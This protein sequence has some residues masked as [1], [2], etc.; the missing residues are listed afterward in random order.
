M[1]PNLFRIALRTLWKNRLSTVV[2]LTGLSVAIGCS[3]ISFLIINRSFVLDNFHENRDRIYQVGNRI[4]IS[5]NLEIWADSP[6][7]LGPAMAEAFPQIEHAV[8]VH[9]VNYSTR[10]GE[11][12]LNESIFFVDPG[13]LDVF[14]FP[15]IEGNADALLDPNST[16]ISERYA[17]KYF[18]DQD[19][20]GQEIVYSIT[21]DEKVTLI[22]QGV[23]QDLPSNASFVFDILVNF[24]RLY[25]DGRKREGNWSGWVTATF[26]LLREGSSI[27]ELE[28]QTGPFVEL[29]NSNTPHWSIDSLFF[30]SLSEASRRSN[31]YSNSL[32]AGVPPLAISLVSLAALS[33]LLLA[34]ANYTNNKLVSIS[35]RFQE[36][37]LR[38]VV[39]GNNRQIMWQ[40]LGENL[41]FLL[42]AFIA[43]VQLSEMLLLP[44]WNQL[45]GEPVL[46]INLYDN[47]YLW[48]F[49]AFL[50][51]I[52]SLV[53]GIYPSVI[54]SRFSAAEIFRFHT[55][56]G[57]QGR[58]I[59]GLVLVQFSIT[60]LFLIFTVGIYQNAMYQSEKDWGYHHKNLLVLY[61]PDTQHFEPFEQRIRALPGVESTTGAWNHFGFAQS[62]TGITIN[63]VDHRI[64]TIR[65]SASYCEFI[66]MNLVAGQ[67]FEEGMTPSS[68]QMIVNETFVREMGWTDPLHETVRID[69]TL[70]TV[71][72][73]VQ[74]FHSRSFLEPI[75][76]MMIRL[77][78]R[79]DQQVLIAR[80][81][82]GEALHVNDQVEEIWSELI[83]DIPYTGYYQDDAFNRLVELNEKLTSLF[84]F[85]GIT[86]MIL[87]LM[88]LIGIV[89]ATL[90]KRQREIA[91]R[92]VMG[93]TLQQVV[94]LVVKPF[95][96]VFCGASLV[97]SLAGWYLFQYFLDTTFVYHIGDSFV[98]II[99]S[100]ALMLFVILV[101]LVFQTVRTALTNPADVLRDF[102]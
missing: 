6:Q 62:L 30:F 42:I 93:A 51:S 97:A 78:G 91:I 5:Q 73:V 100:F 56:T 14:T 50:L 80:V 33:M 59:R 8:R 48:I 38:K 4:E 65:A 85:L 18:G 29:Q 15:L 16:I 25:M 88:G 90:A 96:W 70:H 47:I 101:T 21:P 17:I 35:S 64:E 68:H 19:P 34:C 86:A 40:H 75:E 53:T 89:S 2:N 37:G 61:L 26:I 63:D 58:F 43:G 12:I 79:N 1:L 23:V 102:E 76:A 44:G 67:F 49:L 94:S 95:L 54:A 92:K 28:N 83:P 7:P 69:T 77:S 71:I 27:H 45:I 57:G 72:G 74:D 99:L 60:L 46:D 52:C 20:I 11:E 3:V 98:S 39:G 55:K 24:E 9:P 22:V 36:I 31:D 82:E 84:I 10:L 41:L 81:R 13:F 66:G 32:C 87:S